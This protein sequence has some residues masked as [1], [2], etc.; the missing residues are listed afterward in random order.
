MD[1]VL[2]FTPAK[3]YMNFYVLSILWR[4][5]RYPKIRRDRLQNSPWSYM[6]LWAGLVTGLW[7]KG[8]LF[9]LPNSRDFSG[10][11]EWLCLWWSLVPSLHTWDSHCHPFSLLLDST[12]GSGCDKQ[13][14]PNIWWARVDNAATFSSSLGYLSPTRCQAT[15][16]LP[17]RDSC[18]ES[19]KMSGITEHQTH[20]SIY[21]QH[22]LTSK[23]RS[24]RGQKMEEATPCPG[25]I[26]QQRIS[27]HCRTEQWHPSLSVSREWAPAM[28]APAYCTMHTI[29][30][31]VDYTL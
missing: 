26:S 15:R 5:I 2:K 29:M 20:I 18:V 17:Q 22:I 12:L 9:W 7:N 8:I 6:V 19:F 3:F 24:C 31:T 25:C 27:E 16:S 21:F 1:V 30:Y 4:D 23:R 14:P 11:R 28:A 10:I 13:F